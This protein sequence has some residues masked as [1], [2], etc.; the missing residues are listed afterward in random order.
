[1]ARSV[2]LAWGMPEALYDPVALA[3]ISLLAEVIIAATHA[4]GTLPRDVLDAVLGVAPPVR[5]A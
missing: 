4:P 5:T 2:F 1:V 3:E